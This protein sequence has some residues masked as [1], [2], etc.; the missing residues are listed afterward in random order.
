MDF[1]KVYLSRGIL[2][3][4]FQQTPCHEICISAGNSQFLKSPV[5]ICY[6]DM[7]KIRN[8]FPLS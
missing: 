6:E 3:E 1:L 8:E 5:P 4:S 7:N 2:D